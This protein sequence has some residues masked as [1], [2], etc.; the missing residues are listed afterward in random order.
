M[1]SLSSMNPAASM[2]LPVDLQ[3]MTNPRQSPGSVGKAFESMITSMLI[4]Q[5]RETLDE[6]T[7]FGKD[8]G[9]VLGGLF[10]QIMGDH[11]GST[12]SFGV[13]A[14]IRSQLERRGT[15]E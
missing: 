7:M 5:M 10:D 6:E 12:G 4:K 2:P 14:M 11:L 13:S 9:G 8:S 15:S 1:E 3:Q